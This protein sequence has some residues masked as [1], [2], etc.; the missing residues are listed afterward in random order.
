[1]FTTFGMQKKIIIKKKEVEEVFNRLHT[2][3]ISKAR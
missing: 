2:K 1:M 3:G